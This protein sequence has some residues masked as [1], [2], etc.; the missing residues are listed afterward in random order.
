VRMRLPVLEPKEL[1]PL[2]CALLEA[3]GHPV[4]HP[5]AQDG[6][7]GPLVYANARLRPQPPPPPRRA[8]PSRMSRSPHR[9]PG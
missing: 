8:L 4:Q 2:G 6:S 9:S 1:H 3:V 7:V 5:N